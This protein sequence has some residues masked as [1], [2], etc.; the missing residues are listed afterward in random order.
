NA[1]TPVAGNPISNMLPNDT[2]AVM[3]V[4]MSEVLK[5]PLGNM[6]LN[7]PTFSQA[8]GFPIESIEQL[9]MASKNTEP[10]WQFLILRTKTPIQMESVQ[11]ALKLKPATETPPHGQTY[12]MAPFTLVDLVSSFV[13]PE[14]KAELPPPNPLA[15]RLHDSTTLVMADMAPMQAFL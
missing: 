4:A 8:I 15:V 11:Q 2:Q 14:I 10:Q 13:P 9:I 6:A 7:N 1:P 12:F 5:N 3:T